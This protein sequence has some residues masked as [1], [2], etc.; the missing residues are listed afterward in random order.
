MTA[1]ELAGELRRIAADLRKRER[2]R[3]VFLTEDD[4]ARGWW[5]T[6][7][8]RLDGA[9]ATIEELSTALRDLTG[10]VSG[11]GV[12]PDELV[13]ALEEAG[14]DGLPAAMDLL[15]ALPRLSAEGRAWLLTS[16]R[17]MAVHGVPEPRPMNEQTERES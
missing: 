7:A 5:D 2:W 1:A 9:A 6:D 13:L 8:D 16:L 17:V 10:Y 12:V 14:P 3:N 4:P 15:A 11:R